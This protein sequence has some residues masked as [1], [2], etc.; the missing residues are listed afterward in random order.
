LAKFSLLL[1]DSVVIIELFEIG[2]WD[3][4]L[5]HCDVHVSETIV[6]EVL[7]YIDANDQKQPIDLSRYADKMTIHSLP[8]SRVLELKKGFGSILLDKLDAGEAELLSVV[9][10]SFD[11]YRLCSADAVV[12]RVL[13]ALGKSDQ[14]VSLEELLQQIGLSRSVSWPFSKS[15]R[16][17]WARCGFEEKLHGIILPN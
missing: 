4:I 11:S 1:L 12:F 16:V 15:F 17:H 13:A 8:V 5:A 9:H 2:I 3:Q 10:S 7:Y 6:A 14:G